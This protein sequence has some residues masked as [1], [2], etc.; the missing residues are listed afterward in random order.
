M[1]LLHLVAGCTANCLLLMGDLRWRW[2]QGEVFQGNLE[3]EGRGGSSTRERS[4][5]FLRE[6]VDEG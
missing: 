4:F 2:G 3:G 5:I 6:Q 1:L